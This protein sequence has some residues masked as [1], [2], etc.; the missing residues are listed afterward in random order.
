MAEPIYKSPLEASRA[1]Q[2]MSY[3]DARDKIIDLKKSGK[4]VDELFGLI[5]D[6]V[7]TDSF[8]DIDEDKILDL[9]DYAA[10]SY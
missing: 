2:K 3:R 7:N 4:S 1:L 6:W 9:K 10:D 5:D 8:I